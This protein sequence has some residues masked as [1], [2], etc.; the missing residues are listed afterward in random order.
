[1]YKR[2]YFVKHDKQSQAA[3]HTDAHLPASPIYALPA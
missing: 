1:M 2:V 3:S